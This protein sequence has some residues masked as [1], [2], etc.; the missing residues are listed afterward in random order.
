M[1]SFRVDWQWLHWSSNWAG[2]D[3]YAS[4]PL[5]VGH[6]QID[7]SEEVFQFVSS[8]VI[9]AGRWAAHR[10]GVQETAPG[11]Y[12]LPDGQSNTRQVLISD[13]W[14]PAIEDGACALHVAFGVTAMYGDEH[15]GVRE[16]VIVPTAPRWS[17]SNRN[18]PPIPPNTP[19]RSPVRSRTGLI[20]G[21]VGGSSSLRYL[22]PGV[23]C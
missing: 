3:V 17:S 6:V 14:Q 22:A 18:A 10:R 1:T 13:Q 5:Q 2:F 21:G 11:H 4:E 12:V 15:L 7:R 9:D 16:P 23:H 19:M 20:L 8:R